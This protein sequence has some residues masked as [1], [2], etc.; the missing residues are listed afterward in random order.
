[1][2]D[3]PPWFTILPSLSTPL[4]LTPMPCGTEEGFDMLSV[5]FPA[6]AVAELLSNLSWP[7]GSAESFTVP[8]AAPPPLEVEVVAVEVVAGAAGVLDDV[9]LLLLLLPQPATASAATRATASTWT[10]IGF[11]VL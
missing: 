10:R 8:L 9:L 4:P 1:M 11:M 3:V 7:L 5:T 2:V 6:L